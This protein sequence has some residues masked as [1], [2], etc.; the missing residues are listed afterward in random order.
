MFLKFLMLL[1]EMIVARNDCMIAVC[2]TLISMITNGMC[3]I[4]KVMEI[5]A[6]SG[7]VFKFC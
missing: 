5:W 4:H 1:Q 6:R 2:A 7:L 3:S